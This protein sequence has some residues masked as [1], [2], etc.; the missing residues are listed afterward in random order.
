MNSQKFIDNLQIE[1]NK[2]QRQLNRL[3]KD[4]LVIKKGIEEIQ[5]F[6]KKKISY[7]LGGW[8]K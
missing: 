1:L 6:R 2:T 3:R 8:M 5:E 7:P 4:M